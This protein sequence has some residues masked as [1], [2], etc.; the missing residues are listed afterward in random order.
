[1]EFTEAESNTQDLMCVHFCIQHYR[2]SQS[3]F[4]SCSAEYQQYQEA[5]GDDVYE[6]D[7][8]EEV[9]GEEEPVEEEQ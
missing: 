3:V 8:E 2:N 1:M 9:A 5:T 6:D 7:I 4:I